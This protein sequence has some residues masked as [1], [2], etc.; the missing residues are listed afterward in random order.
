MGKPYRTELAVLPGTYLWATACSIYAL[1]GFLVAARSTPLLRVGSEGSLSVAHLAARL[2]QER[3]GQLARATTPLESVSCR[4][5]WRAV[6]ALILTAGGGNPDV[7]GA[8][9]F[10]RRAEVHALGVICCRPESPLGERAAENRLV[11]SQTLAIPT[12]KD[13]F[14]ATKYAARI[15]DRALAGI[16]G[17][18]G[19]R[20]DVA[21]HARGARLS[22]SERRGV[23]LPTSL[24]D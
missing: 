2:H 7:L 23:R 15:G 1:A 10:F 19:S 11:H 18:V 4:L 9:D 17:R 6:S 12:G 20:G 16:L 5:D 21:R 13:G 22:G 14:L 3:F 8:F 24:S